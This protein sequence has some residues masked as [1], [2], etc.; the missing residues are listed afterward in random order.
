MDVRRKI[1]GDGA[2]SGVNIVPVI[3]LCL[4]LLVILLILSP[5]LDK[6]PLEVVLPKA[7]TAEEK[8][9]NVAITITAEGLMAVNDRLVRDKEHLAT[10]LKNVVAVSQGTD[11]LVVLRSDEKMTYR[12]LTELIKV[13]T[14]AGFLNIAVG[15]EKKK[16]LGQ[17]VRSEKP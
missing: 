10:Y 17:V 5:M 6:S 11:V 7:Q 14:G 1:T 4:V 15:T 16:E 8:Q 3:D 2:I 12:R 9:N 13:V